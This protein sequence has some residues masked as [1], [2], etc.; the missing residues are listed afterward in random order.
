M[1]IL[2]VLKNWQ[3]FLWIIPGVV[4]IHILNKFRPINT[5]N[6][7]GWTYLISCIFLALIT[8]IIVNLIPEGYIPN[9]YLMLLLQSIC[10]FFLAIIASYYTSIGKWIVPNVYDT[11]C[12]NC[13][14]WQ[15]KRI[16][17]TLANRKVYI[18][19]LSKY[20]RNPKERYETQSISIIPLASGY[21]SVDT[22]DLKLKIY[23]DSPE[24]SEFQIIIPR[25]EIVTFSL[26]S[27][28]IFASFNPK[29][30]HP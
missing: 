9:G 22:L 17:V 26:F 7:S 5:V 11:F 1:P 23:Y 15:S 28:K 10:A 19:Y 4:F 13:Y 14:E 12:L 25:K 21:R 29:E 20:P 18:G 30:K 2:E 27:D 3:L 8:S 16:M 6:L 24:D